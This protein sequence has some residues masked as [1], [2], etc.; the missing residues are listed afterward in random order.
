M[1][2]YSG[3]GEHGLI[4]DLQTAALVSTDGTIDRMCCPRFDSP[5]IFASLLDHDRG[6][7]FRICPD[8]DDYVSRQ[9]YFP[10]TAVLI[11]RFMTPDGVGEVVDFTP[12]IGNGVQPPLAH[13]RGAQPGLPVRP[14][15]RL[16]R[17]GALDGPARKLAWDRRRMP[18]PKTVRAQR[19]SPSVPEFGGAHTGLI[20]E[21]SRRVT[22]FFPT[23]VASAHLAVSHTDR[24]GD[25]P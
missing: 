21:G 22:C 16:C 11:T 24:E 19:T 2:R 23:L 3:I 18:R 25:H 6:G 5:S 15:C 10:D 4:G 12:V 13:Q 17:A 14:R 7:H 9:L 20:R 1:D 8:R